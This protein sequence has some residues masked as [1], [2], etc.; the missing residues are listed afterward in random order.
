MNVRFP[1]NKVGRAVVFAAGNE[2][3]DPIHAKVNFAK[4][5]KLV[6]W[7]AEQDTFVKIYFD[8][9]DGSLSI[10]GTQAS[11]LEKNLQIEL[12]PITNQYE[13]TLKVDSRSRRHLA[14]GHCR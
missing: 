1:L 3:S 11:P 5:P 10:V 2:G 12:N 8:S 13:G 7:N 6:S 9:S 14:G 4:E